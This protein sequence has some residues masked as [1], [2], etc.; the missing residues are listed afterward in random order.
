MCRV[1]LKL[2]NYIFKLEEKMPLA[3]EM[4]C[5]ACHGE[6]A[7]S[8]ALSETVASMMYLSRSLKM[9][10]IGNPQIFIIMFSVSF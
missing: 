9:I 5:A 7:N 4:D 8:S 3:T 2:S 6:Q 1:V 10:N